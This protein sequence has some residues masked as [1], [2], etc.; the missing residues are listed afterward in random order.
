MHVIVKLRLGHCDG[1]VETFFGR[2]TV[3]CERVEEV[4]GV[5]CVNVDDV[6]ITVDELRGV[7]A[8][9]LGGFAGHSYE[10]LAMLHAD[11][12]CLGRC[13]TNDTELS[14]SRANVEH[15]RSSVRNQ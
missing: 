14:D 12:G 13:R 2:P 4:D 5:E 8:S 3:F 1:D 15:A 7:R 6:E 11:E 10:V 9:E